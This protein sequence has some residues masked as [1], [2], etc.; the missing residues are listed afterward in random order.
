ML[1]KRIQTKYGEY[2]VSEDGIVRLEKPFE[3]ITKTGKHWKHND[4]GVIKPG[5]SNSGYKRIKLNGKNVYIHRIVC[6]AFNG[7]PPIDG[8]YVDHID[9]NKMNNHYTNLEWVTPKENSVRAS[10]NGLINTESEKRKAQAPI[11]AKKGL[12]KT[13]KHSYV[14]YNSDGSLFKTITKQDL[15]EHGREYFKIPHGTMDR[16][17]HNGKF[18]RFYEDIIEEYGYIPEKIPLRGCMKNTHARKIIYVTRKDGK[19]ESFLYYTQTNQKDRIINESFNRNKPDKNGDLW[20]I[21][22]R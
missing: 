7:E 19:K 16:I 3:Y 18:W 10:K 2:Y 9:G 1:E 13:I 17:S 5:M 21:D 20:F 22:L 6:R 11:N 15:I 12:A 8:M 14:I 4:F